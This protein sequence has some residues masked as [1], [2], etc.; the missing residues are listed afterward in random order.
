VGS[1]TLQHAFATHAAQTN[2]L[3]VRWL[4]FERVFTKIHTL[5]TRPSPVLFL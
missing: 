1:A 2:P 5:S 4:F 3:L